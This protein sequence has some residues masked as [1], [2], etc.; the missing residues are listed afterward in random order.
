MLT[1]ATLEVDFDFHDTLTI[2][3]N[4]KKRDTRPLNLPQDPLALSWASYWITKKN[5]QRRWTPLEE[6]TASTHDIEM[7][8]VTRKYYRDKIMMKNLRGTPMTQFQQDLYDICNN[9][10]VTHG[11]LGMLYRLP[12]FYEED[13]TKQLLY[14]NHQPVQ[15]KTGGMAERRT[16][17]LTPLS[18]IVRS[19]ARNETIQFW[20]QDEGNA[21]VL[22]SVLHNNPLRPLVESLVE[23]GTI[24]VSAFFHLKNDH[25][26]PSGFQFWH[27]GDVR[28]V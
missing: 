2:G 19:R 21:L 12:Y 22:W 26:D 14:A 25:Y 28:L 23:K 11:H 6:L 3:N 15:G 16:K 13:T 8:E 10:V 4:T 17:T 5:P 24:T 9:G 20:F 27:I 18:T 7:A 1:T